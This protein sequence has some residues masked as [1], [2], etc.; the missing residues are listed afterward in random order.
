MSGKTYKA[1]IYKDVGNIVLTELPYPVC[2]DDDII[3]KN[4]MSGICGS[5]VAAFNLDGDAQMIWKDSEFGHEMVSEVVEIGKNVKDIALGDHVFPNMGQAHRDRRRMCTVGAFSEYVHIKQFEI[6]YSAI[7][8]DKSIPLTSAVLL[9]PFVVGTRGAKGTNPG[10]GKTAIV[11]GPGII[12]MSAAIMFK[13]FGC[14]KVM[15]VGNSDGRLEKAKK[16]GIVTCNPRKEDLKKKAIDEFGSARCY[17]GE[18]CGANLYVDAL[19]VNTGIE[20]FAKIAGRNSMLSVV[21]VHHDPILFDFLPVTFNNWHISGSGSGTYEELAPEVLAMM[22]SGKFD[23]SPLVS[24]QFKLDD[25]IEA[26]KI[27]G[28]SQIGRANSSH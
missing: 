27:A 9:E 2:G 16:Y 15:I 8:I 26:I 18:V 24:H 1:A 28:N 11:F 7:K 25:I 6:N 21:G 4:L 20:Y 3:V 14:D 23:L 10:P 22:Q 5:D 17:T 12:G 13:W 19:P